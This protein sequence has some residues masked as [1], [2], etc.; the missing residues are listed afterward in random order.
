M[1]LQLIIGT[2]LDRNEAWLKEFDQYAQEQKVPLL[3]V[4]MQSPSV[5]KLFSELA[6]RLEKERHS[7]MQKRL[8]ESGPDLLSEKELLHVYLRILQL[9][10]TPK[11]KS[12]V[13]KYM[14]FRKK[15]ILKNECKIVPINNIDRIH[16]QLPYYDT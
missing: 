9:N 16:T 4:D 6:Q 1:S 11:P 13:S 12:G 2:I 3:Y 7:F 10:S 5:N 15:E 8:K 14:C